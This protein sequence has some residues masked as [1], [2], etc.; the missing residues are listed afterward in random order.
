[1]HVGLNRDRIFILVDVVDRAHSRELV[2]VL[3]I[4]FE[5]WSSLHLHDASVVK[6]L[7]DEGSFKLETVDVVVSELVEECKLLVEY[8]F[9]VNDVHSFWELRNRLLRNQVV[10][11]QQNDGHDVRGSWEMRARSVDIHVLEEVAQT[12]DRLDGL[13]H[14]PF[15]VADDESLLSELAKEQQKVTHKFGKVVVSLLNFMC[16]SLLVV[17][18]ELERT[19]DHLLT[20]IEERNDEGALAS[21]D[22]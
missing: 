9:V 16:E 13:L 8:C 5:R 1:M 12:H 20:D 10:L 6:Q 7:L 21:P 2:G 18:V 19:N 3:L 14:L 11:I 15:E 22:D 17:L 4:I